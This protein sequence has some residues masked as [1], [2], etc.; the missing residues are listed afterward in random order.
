MSH[1]HRPPDPPYRDGGDHTRHE[2]VATAC[3]E[4]LRHDIPRF[5]PI[6][7][8]AIGCHFQRGGFDEAVDAGFRRRIGRHSGARYTRPGDGGGEND[9]PV[10]LRSHCGQAGLGCQKCA[11]E[12]DPQNRLQS[13]TDVSSIKDGGS[14][15]PLGDR[16]AP[17][18][19]L[20][21]PR[22]GPRQQVALPDGM[23]AP[24]PCAAPMMI[25][26]RPSSC[27]VMSPPK[28]GFCCELWSG[29]SR[30]PGEDNVR[31]RPGRGLQRKPPGPSCLD[32]QCFE[33]ALS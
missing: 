33:S 23:A 5:D 11:G 24:M 1:V 12:V 30:P 32:R 19:P 22:C 28:K 2:I 20:R 18:A 17:R 9:P 15:P 27:P 16:A 10:F 13:S 14:M 7:R 29:L 6:H 21:H 25:A 31:Q 8:D 4:P 26:I 3:G